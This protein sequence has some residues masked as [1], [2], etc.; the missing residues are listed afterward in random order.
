MT[1]AG[2]ALGIAL[3]VASAVILAGDIRSLLGG[4]LWAGSLVTLLLA[5]LGVRGWPHSDSL[6]TS[7]DN[8]FFGR[9]IPKIPARI[10]AALAAAIMAVALFLRLYN[11]EYFPG[12]EQDEVFQAQD[13]KRIVEGNPAP[14]FGEGWY[15]VP[16]LSFYVI[17]GLMRVFGTDLYGAR[18][19][20]LLAGLVTVW[21]VYRTARL[22]WGPRAGLIAGLMMAISPLAL[23]YSRVLNVTTGTQA[24]WAAG[25]FYLFMALRFRK[26][27]DWFLAGTLWAF[28]LYFYPAG[29]LI[30]P[31]AG[32]VWLYC[33]I[34]WRKEF[35]KRY[36]LGSMLMWLGLLLVFM[37]YG[38]FSAKEN[39]RGFSGRAQEASIFSPRHQ[40]EVFARYNVPHDPDWTI[41]PVQQAVL[42]NPVAWGQVVLN[43]T[44]VAFEVLYA[45]SDSWGFYRI[46]EHNGSLFQPLWAALALLGMAYAIW[47]LWDARFGISLI[48][49]W[50]GLMG[51][52]LMSDLPN[53]LRIS[54]VWSV[55]M[56]FPTAL[57]DRVLA[58]AWPLN[59]SLARR[60]VAVPLAALLIYLGADSVREYFVHWNSLC[61]QCRPTTQA[62]YLRSLGTDYRVYEIASNYDIWFGQAHTS[63][64]APNAVGSDVPA[65]ADVLPISDESD[66]GAVFLASPEHTSY[67]EVVRSLYPGGQ[68]EAI[69]T[70]DGVHLL[71]AYKLTREQLAAFQVVQATYVPHQGAPTIREEAHLGMGSGWTPPQGSSFPSSAV[72]QG[73]LVVPAYGT[74][75][76]QVTGGGTLELDGEVIIGP[77]QSDVGVQRVLAKGVHQVRLTGTIRDASTRIEVLWGG[78]SGPAGP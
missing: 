23:Q 25:F 14:I 33:L 5:F 4:W 31:V 51:V 78:G 50:G 57:L 73:G 76:L 75:T 15:W 36:L 29:K 54:T 59:I 6:L 16:N 34:R 8:E 24:L 48:W 52:A 22:L 18:I 28:N 43:Q 35:F 13:A 47:R 38:I 66:K 58:A 60:W 12:V 37:P 20:P 17:A 77:E 67:L 9:G 69:N 44:R 45:R 68:Y 71:T 10:E 1:L 63:F 7:P 53:V 3:A 27:T 74:Y 40:A 55:V 64:L 56:F 26:P 39:W 72:W 65:P 11:L 70:P 41:A 49:F 46:R 32:A 21:Y 30:L 62:R 2:L 42:S 61:Y 19:M